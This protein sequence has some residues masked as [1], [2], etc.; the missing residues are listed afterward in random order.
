MFHELIFYVLL[1]NYLFCFKV[2]KFFLNVSK[3]E[4]KRRFLSRLED[5][6]KNW[7]FSV[8]DLKEC[9]YWD[10]YM[11][12]YSD[13][14]THTST[15]E[16]PWYVIP[17]DNKWFMRYAVSEIVIN[18]LRGLPLSFPN[19]PQDELNKLD[20]ARLQLEN[21]NLSAQAAQ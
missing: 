3:E 18:R 9:S 11:K 1:L 20:E 10:D 21:E 7:K 5:E 6:A 8:S 14:L 4:Q 15:E 2:I 16:A 19:L 17:A 13:M 12:A